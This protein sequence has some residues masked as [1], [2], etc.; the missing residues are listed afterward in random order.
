MQ[1]LN[2]KYIEVYT[3]LVHNSFW[4]AF[5]EWS[6]TSMKKL[7]FFFWELNPWSNEVQKHFYFLKS[8]SFSF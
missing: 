8:D 4:R 5:K 1:T 6:G 2:L 7:F 3:L